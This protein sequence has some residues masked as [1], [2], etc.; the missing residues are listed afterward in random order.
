MNFSSILKQH[1][2]SYAVALGEG[3]ESGKD[4]VS[5]G[6]RSLLLNGLDQ[7]LETVLDILRDIIHSLF[8][9]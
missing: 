6:L 3:E 1:V 2:K 7:C 8:I 9:C 4:I 5:Y